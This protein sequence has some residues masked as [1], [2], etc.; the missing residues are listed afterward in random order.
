[1]SYAV[2]RSAL[3][4]AETDAARAKTMMDSV[5]EA[6]SITGEMREL[7]IAVEV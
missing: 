4:P 6:E 7:G 3:T 5:E 1:M 2:L